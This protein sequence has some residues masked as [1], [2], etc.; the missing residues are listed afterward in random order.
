MFQMLHPLG[1]VG[2]F[3]RPRGPR[4]E[5]VDQVRRDARHAHGPVRHDGPPGHAVHLLPGV[6]LLLRD[7]LPPMRIERRCRLVCRARVDDRSVLS[8]IGGAFWT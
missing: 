6:G 8:R 3:R 2:R 4:A 1:P 7:W 5:P